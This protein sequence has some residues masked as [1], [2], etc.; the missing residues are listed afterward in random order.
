MKLTVVIVNYNVKF[1]LEQCLLSVIN[2]L[3]NMNAEVVV[4]DNDSADGSC[5]MVKEKFPNVTLIENKK[6]VGFS[7]ANNIAMQQSSAEYI[8][9]LN[10]DTLVEEDTFKKCILYMDQHPNVGSLGVKMIDGK[11]NFLPESKRGMPTPWVSFCKIFGLSFFF[12]KSKLFGKYHLGYLPKDAINEV[13]ILPGAFMLLRKSVLDQVGLLDEDFFMYGEDIDLSYRILKAGYKNIY[14]PETTIIH[15]KGESTKKGSINYVIVFYNAMIIFARKHFSKKNAR[16]FSFFINLAVYFRASIAV[17]K[18]IFVQLFLPV[19]DAFTFYMGFIVAR[20]YWENYKFSGSGTYPVFFLNV[21]VPAYIL[22]W[23]ISIWLNGGYTRPFRML[24]VRRGILAGTLAILLVYALLPETLRF[25]RALIIIGTAWA[26]LFS[27]INRLVVNLFKTPFTTEFTKAKKRIVIVGEKNEAERVYS[28]LRHSHII[29]ELIGIVGP[30]ENTSKEYMGHLGQLNDIIRINNIEEII[31][32]GKNLSS[33]EII[34]NMLQFSR[35]NVE[36][37]IAPP[38]SLSVIGSNSINTAGDLYTVSFNS[39][40]KPS[41][42][43]KKRFFDIAAALALLV[44]S[45]VLILWM[46]KPKNFFINLFGVLQKR[47]SF[48]GFVIEGN[49]EYERLEIPGIFYPQNQ[50]RKH[51]LTEEAKTRMNTEYAQNYSIKTDLNILIINIMMLDAPPF[52][53]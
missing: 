42:R 17:I 36:F 41:N 39:V 5:Q 30:T 10:P 37:K 38:E 2:A 23:L 4:V 27:H 24:K 20:P 1:F 31:F 34:K 22:F 45:P 50:I 29:P 35:E 53:K 28:I 12:P 43:R 40:T 7:K 16:L 19:L 47:F 3:K 32:C 26:L 18:R 49:T 46:H 9:L 33:G 44:L 6:N 15:Y 13:E 11:G 52:H 25:S 51:L 8:L 21:M 48:V 14:F